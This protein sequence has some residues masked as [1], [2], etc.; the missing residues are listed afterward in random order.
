ME[1][2][3]VQ[4]TQAVAQ[5]TAALG[6]GLSRQARRVMSDSPHI[7]ITPRPAPHSRPCCE[8]RRVPYLG[9]AAFFAMTTPVGVA[10]GIGIRSTYN[11]NSPAA[12]AT[13]GVFDSISTGILIYMALVCGA[14]AHGSRCHVCCVQQVANGV[15]RQQPDTIAV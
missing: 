10:V 8:P 9:L 2:E 14:T 7:V 13:A 12:L 11:A 1:I 4:S 15:P 3:H 5:A 6:P